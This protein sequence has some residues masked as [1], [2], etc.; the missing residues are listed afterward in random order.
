MPFL[1]LNVWYYQ[2]F[3]QDFQLK[4][5]LCEFYGAS[6]WGCGLAEFRRR[7]APPVKPVSKFTPLLGLLFIL[8][9]VLKSS[10]G[11]GVVNMTIWQY[12]TVIRT[13]NIA[14]HQEE[15][16][17]E[18]KALW[19]HQLDCRKNRASPDF[20][21][22]VIDLNGKVSIPRERRTGKG[23]ILE[24]SIDSNGT[25]NFQNFGSDILFLNSRRTCQ[26]FAK[27]L[28]D[29]TKE[30]VCHGFRATNQS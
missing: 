6:Q 10:T 30:K 2:C 4:L 28:G 24:V 25:K 9:Y 17:E 8:L 15:K 29:F 18:E 12:R 27:L 23:H 1:S 11:H 22:L 7:T 3:A 5:I 13:H 14:K 16:E 19:Q 20:L 26:G 21:L